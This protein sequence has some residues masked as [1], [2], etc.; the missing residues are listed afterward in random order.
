MIIYFALNIYLDIFYY[1]SINWNNRIY[2][3]SNHPN[4]FGISIVLLLS[5]SLL[6]IHKSSYIMK[7]TLVAVT[8]LTVYYV[9][10]T[11]SRTAALT[12]TV[13]MLPWLIW[14]LKKFSAIL[15]LFIFATPI[16]V[17]YVLSN[18]N[19]LDLL[20]GARVFSSLNTR[21]DTFGDMLSNFM[22]NPI[23]GNPATVGGTSN[24]YLYAASSLGLV[25]ITLLFMMIGCVFKDLI[26]LTIKI[27]KLG[28]HFD[29]IVA[30]YLVSTFFGFIISMTLSG[31]L[32]EYV[33]FPLLLFIVYMSILVRFKTSYN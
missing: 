25:G 16:S 33:Q 15:I 1:D 30:V 31:Y 24:T 10:R 20:G 23:L 5:T 6:N 17:I 21:S 11:G 9:F 8:I 7:A 12:L 13:V 28:N 3:L 18:P 29:G 14:L 32:L 26:L 19:I 2:G 22:H 4:E 27:K